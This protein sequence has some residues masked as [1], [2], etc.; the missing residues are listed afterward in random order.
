MLIKNQ[1]ISTFYSLVSFISQKHTLFHGILLIIISICQIINI[2]RFTKDYKQGDNRQNSLYHVDMAFVRDYCSTVIKSEAFIKYRVSKHWNKHSTYIILF[3]PYQYS[4]RKVSLN[5][6]ID[7]KIEI[8]IIW[9]TQGLLISEGHKIWTQVGAIAKHHMIF[10]TTQYCPLR[11]FTNT[12]ANL[13]F[14]L[15]NATYI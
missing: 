7:E 6:F 11:K 1:N 3:S 4:M 5:C 12:E 13:Y 10:N 2:F 15:L 8:Q 9:F 14:I